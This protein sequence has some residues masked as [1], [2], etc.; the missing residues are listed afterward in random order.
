VPFNDLARVHRET[1]TE[2][3]A[4]IS[5]VLERGNYVLGPEVGAF[6]TEFA[7]YLGIP[8]CVGVANGTDALELALQAV[9][10]HPGAPVIL[11]S[12]AG[13]YA[14]IAA[15]SAG[16]KPQYADVVPESLLLTAESIAPHLTRDTAAVVITHLYGQMAVMEPIAEL[17]QSLGVPLIE[18]C[19]QAVGASRSGRKAGTFGD[20]STFSFYPTKNL[21]ALGDAGA[22][23]TAN[24]ELSA[25][26]RRLRQYGWSQ[27]GVVAIPGGRNSRLDE[28]QAAVLR[29]RLRHLDGW[30]RQRRCLVQHYASAIKQS[31]RSVLGAT[32][33]S[34]VG[35]LAV[36][37]PKDRSTFV[38]HMSRL[39]IGVGYHFSHADHLQPQLAR[40]AVEQTAELTTTEDACRRVVSIP[41]FPQLTESEISLVCEALRAYAE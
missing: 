23:A 18:D 20:L 37:L 22:V 16:L 24:Q 40:F 1:K 41:T 3:A 5:R 38:A 13:G 6:E 21:G 36:V 26:L 9:D 32:D 33:E 11:A 27:R 30:N 19:A 14:S 39:G 29:V 4:A 15:I 2:T 12:N 31:Y 28:V 7:R 25:S 34:Y 17:C 35:H 8:H 10:A